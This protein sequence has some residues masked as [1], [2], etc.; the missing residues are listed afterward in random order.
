VHIERQAIV[1][2][3]AM[4]K[5][6]HEIME[7]YYNIFLQLC[8]VIPQQPNNVYI[9]KTLK[10]KLKKL[11]LAIIGMFRTTIVKIANSTREIEEEMPTKCKS[12]QF[13]P[14]SG[15][16]NLNEESVNDEQKKERRKNYKE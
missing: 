3:R 2:L 13:Q 7:D 16:E 14:L 4:K 12:K 6:K 9:R 1:A 5:W 8:V 10:E 11:K 15:N